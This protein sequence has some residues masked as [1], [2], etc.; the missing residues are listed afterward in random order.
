MPYSALQQPI[1]IGGKQAR[2]RLM[3]TTHGPRLG[4]ARYLGYLEARAKGGVAL[5]GFNLGP[6]GIMQFPLGPGRA[7]A[8]EGGDMDAIPPHPLTPEGKS[9]YDAMIPSSR[10]W[11]DA[12]AKHGT[13]AVG[14][15]YHPGIAQHSDNFQPAIGASHG[16]DDYERKNGR[17]LS[18]EQIADLIEAY[19][20]GAKRAVQ[21]GFDM[22]EMHA[23]HGYMG[24]QFLSPLFNK[25]TDKYGGSY[26]NRYRFLGELIAAVKEKVAG[27]VPIGLRVNGPDGAPGGLSLADVV[28]TAKRAEAA[29]LAYVSVSGGTYSGLLE[30]AHLPYVAPAFIAA[31]PNVPASKAVKQAVKIPVLVTGRIADIDFAERVVASGEAD[32]VGMVRGLVADPELPRKAFSG[33]SARIIPCIACNECHY[34]R[35]L[36]CSTNPAAGREAALQGAPAA[37]AKNVLIVGAGPAGIECALAAARRGHHVTLADRRSAVG[38]MVLDLAKVSE[39]AE[40][41][42]Y[43]TYAAHALAESSVALKLG[44]DIDAAYVE[45]LGAD[46]VVLATGAKYAPLPDGALS[47]AAAMATPDK[48]GK[49]VVVAGGKD[50][51]LAPLVLADCL[52]RGGRQVTLLTEVTAPGSSVE[53]ASLNLLLRRLSERKVTMLPLTAALKREGSSVI[54]RNSYTR[55]AGRIDN[56]DSLVVVDGLLPE[57][58]LAA[59]LKGKVKALH[60]IGDAL[61]PRRMVHATL[62]G[63]RLGIAL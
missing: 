50:D 11:R 18:A 61:A 20:L 54:T 60:L 24:H 33:N 34:G 13:I 4:Q 40:F 14:Q 15:L 52:A 22:I 42:K 56:V 53:P 58:S 51:H 28:E 45:W 7:S 32:L 44:V 43:L 25:R 59:Q 36:T 9:H 46:E 3:M 2:N 39:Q 6:M 62:D 48:I 57:E 27:A 63:A 23:A 1:T 21:A 29:G 49:R 47:G 16:M 19:A 30:G 17:G 12:V 38:G 37:V 26:E 10:A 31:G 41:G 8:A 35:P 55:Q 5:A